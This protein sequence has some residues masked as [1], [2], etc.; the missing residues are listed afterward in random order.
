M[1]SGGFGCS[2]EK[3]L[4]SRTALFLRPAPPTARGLL[5]DAHDDQGGAGRGYDQQ[6]QD[7]QPKQRLIQ[8]RVGIE[9]ARPKRFR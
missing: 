7:C 1:T 5:H 2:A 6:R 9:T 8:Q 4:A 3:D